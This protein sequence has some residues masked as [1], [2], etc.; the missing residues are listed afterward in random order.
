MKHAYARRD[1]EAATFV[2]DAGYFRSQAREAVLS[3]LA[4]LNGIYTAAVGDRAVAA[5]RLKKHA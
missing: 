4:P 3:F 5:Q 1:R 2:V